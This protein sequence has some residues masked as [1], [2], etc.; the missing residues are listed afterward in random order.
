M[1]VSRMYSE[2]GCVGR[3]IL[4]HGRSCRCMFKGAATKVTK[5]EEFH[6]PTVSV[7]LGQCFECPAGGCGDVARRHGDAHHSQAT[8]NPKGSIRSWIH[9]HWESLLIVSSHAK[10][11]AQATTHR[12][13]GEHHQ[14]LS[15][16]QQSLNPTGVVR[17][18]Y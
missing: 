6:N 5:H 4:Q 2:R 11:T 10:C 13:I 1:S 15:M 16:I 8:A 3:Q 9:S 14:Q 17:I 7:T 12:W 18:L